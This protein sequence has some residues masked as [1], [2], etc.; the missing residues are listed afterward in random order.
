VTDAEY[1]GW[2]ALHCEATAANAEAAAS[3]LSPL[4]RAAF[5]EWGATPGE[6]GECTHRLLKYLRVPKFANEHA[7]SVAIQLQEMRRERSTARVAP[8][9]GPG[10]PDCALCGDSALVTV[11]HWLCVC[12]PA[13]APPYLVN[14]VDPRPGGV[15]DYGRLVC[16]DVRC[17]ECQRGLH[18]KSRHPSLANYLRNFQGRI[19]G[20]GVAELLA[21]HERA[22]AEHARG[23][24]KGPGEE[25]WAALVERIRRRA[26]V[27]GARE[28]GEAA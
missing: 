11:P 19:S 24:A 17:T 4:N 28:Q 13:D 7:E 5:E 10:A 15:G 3:L 23:G 26:S 16:I 1:D 20:R 27:A 9:R 2:V 6:L 21:A 8:D 22:K 18:A 12:V 14:F 25:V